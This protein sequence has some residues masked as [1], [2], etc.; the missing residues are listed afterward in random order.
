M[1]A[2]ISKGSRLTP[3]LPGQC[4]ERPI[5]ERVAEQSARAV[6]EARSILAAEEPNVYPGYCRQIRDS[7]NR[8]SLNGFASDL[9]PFA[10]LASALHDFDTMSIEDVAALQ[11]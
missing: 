2:R 6:A 5:R 3:R 10:C 9:Q 1:R 4:D 11:A 7:R 8:Y